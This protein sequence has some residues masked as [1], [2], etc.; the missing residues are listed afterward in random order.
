M[1]YDM[2]F[3]GSRDESVEDAFDKL[4]SQMR[5][6][7]PLD[8]FQIYNLAH[9]IDSF[10]LKSVGESDKEM[11]EKFI[12]KFSDIAS[13][14]KWESDP[15]KFSYMARATELGR[16]EICLRTQHDYYY[17]MMKNDELY[18]Y[19]DLLSAADDMAKNKGCVDEYQK[20][21]EKIQEDDEKL[22][23]AEW[24]EDW[25]EEQDPDEVRARVF[26]EERIDPNTKDEDLPWY[27]SNRLEK[28]GAY[29]S[30][31]KL[32]AERDKMDAKD[33]SDDI[34]DQK[35]DMSE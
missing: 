23:Y 17:H 8:P 16:G 31:S 7:E 5:L 15:K 19:Y 21:V 1:K 6:D 12:D 22:M 35:G 4:Q 2:I 26:E 10:R 29:N 11:H 34:Q 30:K 27:V 28:E 20:Y 32:F 9:D 33:N 13:R 24:E 14:F 18:V 25:R 3:D